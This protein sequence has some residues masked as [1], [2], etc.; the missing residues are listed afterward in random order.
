MTHTFRMKIVSK[1]Q[2]TIPAG[3]LELLHI[4]EGDYL[5]VEVGESKREPTLR[6]LTLAP[7]SYFPDKVLKKLDQRAAEIKKGAYGEVQE[8]SKL[9]TERANRAG[10]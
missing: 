2:V 7:T 8:V 5:E 10:V 1:R 3:L 6:G 9:P 4:R